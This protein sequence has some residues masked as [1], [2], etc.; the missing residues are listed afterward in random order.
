MCLSSGACFLACVIDANVHAPHLFVKASCIVNRREGTSKDTYEA[1]IVF[2]QKTYE[3]NTKHEDPLKPQ[4]P[5]S[6]S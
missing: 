4:L 1:T 6:Y 3:P 5:G 2:D